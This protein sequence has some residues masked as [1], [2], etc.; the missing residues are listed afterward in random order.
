MRPFK[1]PHVAPARAASSRTLPA[2]AP[3]IDDPAKAIFDR[4]LLHIRDRRTLPTS[5]A[6][7][8]ARDLRN[9]IAEIVD[10]LNEIRPQ[11]E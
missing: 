11:D 2:F 10:S 3:G 6:G 4:V 5:R 9:E 8:L 7:S 1:P